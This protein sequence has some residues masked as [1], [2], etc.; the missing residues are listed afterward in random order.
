MLN[1]NGEYICSMDVSSDIFIWFQLK[2]ILENTQNFLFL[3]IAMYWQERG[4]GESTRVT[5]LRVGGGAETANR[6]FS[7]ILIVMKIYLTQFQ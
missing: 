5:L 4:M 7:V 3:V 1:W 2:E 6:A